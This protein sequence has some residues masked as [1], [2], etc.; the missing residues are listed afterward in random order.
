MI[1]SLKRGRDWKA[2]LYTL[3]GESTSPSIGFISNGTHSLSDAHSSD[4]ANSMRRDDTQRQISSSDY[5]LLS[6]LNPES[7]SLTQH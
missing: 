7:V 1:Q 3:S 4:R 2:T 6:N 5:G